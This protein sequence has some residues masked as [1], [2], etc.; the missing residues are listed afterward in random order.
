MTNNIII[1]GDFN[2]HVDN[3]SCPLAVEF[4]SLLDCLGLQQ[5]VEAPTHNKGYTLDLAIT[6]S[7][8]VKNLEVYDLGVSDHKSQ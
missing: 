4:L 1:I 6:N 3:P 5:H 7:A 2:I 8:S